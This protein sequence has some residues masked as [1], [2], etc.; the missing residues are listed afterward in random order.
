MPQQTHPFAEFIKILGKGKRGARPLTQDEAYRAMK[1]IVNHEVKAEQLG[2]F[3]MLMRIKEETPEELAGFVLAVRE[4]LNT[5]EI[6]VDLDW[7]SY[8]GKRR[9][10]PWFLLSVLVLAENNIKIFMHGAKGTT[11]DRI[12]TEDALNT[13]NISA[14]RSFKEVEAQLAQQNFSYLPLHYLS[15]VLNDIMNLRYLMGLRSPVHTLVRLLNP[16]N[17]TYTLQGIFHPSYRDV[18]QHAAQLMGQKNMAVLKGEGGETEKNPDSECL[19]KSVDNGILTE[20]LWSPLFSRRH[21]K[22]DYLDPKQLLNIW[23]GTT[24]DEFAQATIIGT[25]AV[26][27]KVMKKVENQQQAQDVARYYWEKRDKQKFL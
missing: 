27:L 12:Y 23:Q 5:P 10:L 24:Q 8:A 7:S 14:A 21:L 16:L 18:H 9:H 13:L 1:M 19:I 20:E 6:T 25:M 3:L 22:S 17:A 2:A 4:S 15:P 11:D 26:A